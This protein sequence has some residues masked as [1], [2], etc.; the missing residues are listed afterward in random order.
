[1]S[2]T[3]IRI[4]EQLKHR[5]ADAASSSGQTSHAFVL[6]AIESTLEQTERSNAFHGDAEARWAELLASGQSVPWDKARA[7]LKMR[8]EG[9]S[10]VKPRGRKA[11]R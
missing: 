3:T 11:S 7:W 5:I 8:G 9:K 6:A 2:T 10:L 4:D 1:M